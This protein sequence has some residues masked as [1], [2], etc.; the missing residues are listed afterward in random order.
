M[1]ILTPDE[2]HRYVLSCLR[3]EY[4]K[5]HKRLSSLLASEND[6]SELS[7]LAL[8]RTMKSLKKRIAVVEEKTYPDILA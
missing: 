6:E 8:M 5:C 3:S 2:T 7:L 4:D 1:N